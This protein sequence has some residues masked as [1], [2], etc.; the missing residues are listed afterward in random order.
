M[1]TIR[2]PHCYTNLG[3][4]GLEGHYRQKES[5][6]NARLVQNSSSTNNKGGLLNDVIRADHDDDIFNMDVGEDDTVADDGMAQPFAAVGPPS[7]RLP[8]PPPPV[9]SSAALGL[10][11]SPPADVPSMPSTAL[12]APISS[13]VH[14]SSTIPPMVLAFEEAQFKLDPNGVEGLAAQRRLNKEAASDLPSSSAYVNFAKELYSRTY[15]LAALSATTTAEFAAAVNASKAPEGGIKFNEFELELHSFLRRAGCPMGL[16]ESVRGLVNQVASH[17]SSSTLEKG[18]F[19][20]RTTMDHIHRTLLEFCQKTAHT[21]WSDTI[22]YPELWDVPTSIEGLPIMGLDPLAQL[23]SKLVDP[24]VMLGRQPG[25]IQMDPYLEHCSVQNGGQPTRIYTG[26]MSSDGAHGARVLLDQKR[27]TCGLDC[28]ILP[29]VIYADGIAV[30]W[31]SGVSIQNTL[32]IPGWFSPAMQRELSSPVCTGFS[33]SDI[34]PS[35]DQAL[36]VH[37][38]EVFDNRKTH[39]EEEMRLLKRHAEYQWWARLLSYI[40]Y[41]WKHGVQMMVLGKGI[42]TV[43][44]YIAFTNADDPQQSI[45]AGTL[46]GNCNCGCRYCDFPTRTLQ[47][48][49]TSEHPK[50]VFHEIQ[51]HIAGKLIFG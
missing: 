34:Y 22:K 6:R 39:V 29:L 7:P 1:T 46:A 26:T 48:Y 11:S 37:L 30:G 25:D 18:A 4:L 47:F 44:P 32:M 36:Y 31:G 33:P 2:C 8:P 45:F 12:P 27:T 49:S 42:V 38:M 24:E 35:G 9:V 50:R 51:H 17:Y 23:Q 40:D 28:H 20:I 15:G 13:E 43:Y 5:C 19:P 16:Q 10:Q 14:E 41:A 3:K 21:R